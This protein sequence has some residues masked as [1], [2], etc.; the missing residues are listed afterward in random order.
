MPRVTKK[1]LL[2]V[3]NVAACAATTPPLPKLQKFPPRH[4]LQKL[5]QQNNQKFYERLIPYILWQ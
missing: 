5:P 2:L 4:P 1:M 3:A